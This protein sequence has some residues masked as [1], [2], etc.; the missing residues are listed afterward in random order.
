MLK[1]TMMSGGSA[2]RIEKLLA[3]YQEQSKTTV[4]KID[5]LYDHFSQE[6]SFLKT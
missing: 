3:S 5:A 2:E 4:E 1:D 6:I